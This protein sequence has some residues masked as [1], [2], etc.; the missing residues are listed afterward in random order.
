MAW[1][2]SD[3]H[4][5]RPHHVKRYSPIA[6]STKCM[7]CFYL[8]VF[9]WTLPSIFRANII[10][11]V[12]LRVCAFLSQK[13][14]KRKAFGFGYGWLTAKSTS[15]NPI[16]FKCPSNHALSCI[17]VDPFFV[18]SVLHWLSTASYAWDLQNL[19]STYCSWC[20]FTFD[21]DLDINCLKYLPGISPTR[22]IFSETWL[23]EV[24]QPCAGIT[25]VCVWSYWA[26]SNCTE[27]EMNE[28]KKCALLTARCWFAAKETR[29][30]LLH[31]VT[32][33][34]SAHKHARKAIGGFAT[35]S[36]QMRH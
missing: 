33:W 14:R 29:P 24:K 11:R 18:C 27:K 8:F 19:A 16:K 22:L 15:F 34:C 30:W 7:D 5:L 31:P 2:Q 12:M 28:T 21:P 17:K 20:S 6:K 9:F 32:W 3:Q 1:S 25:C 13:L 4:R 10:S 35:V 23:A 26:I 36:I